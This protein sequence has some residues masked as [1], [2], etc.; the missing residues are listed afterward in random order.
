[1]CAQIL[2]NYSKEFIYLIIYRNNKIGSS[3]SL[4]FLLLLVTCYRPRLCVFFLIWFTVLVIIKLRLLTSFWNSCR[5]PEKVIIILNL[6]TQVLMCFLKTSSLIQ[7]AG[8]VIS[9]C[10]GLPK[11]GTHL[12]TRN[13]TSVY[14]WQMQRGGKMPPPL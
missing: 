9:L 14:V 1:M 5:I 3:F 12:F 4:I 2:R 7:G 8:F 10:R 11:T 6:W 13:A